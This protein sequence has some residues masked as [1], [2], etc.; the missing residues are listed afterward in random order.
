MQ[1]ER[2]IRMVAIVAICVAVI[3]LSIGYAAI[4]QTMNVKG[5]TNLKGNSWN[6]QFTN[7]IKP[8]L[9][10]GGLVGS[11][12]EVSSTLTGTNL[13]FSANIVLPGDTIVYRWSVTNAGTIDAKLSATPVL[14]GLDAAK[15]K[16][17]LYTMTYED[18][19][20]IQENDV[21]NA[22]ETKNI[23]LTVAF[24]QAATTI[25]STDTELALSTTLNYVQK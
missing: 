22:G 3:A 17:V 9:Q 18:G 2:G 4:N 1:K 7:L 13:S 24:A 8:T 5:T 11:A 20:A 14:A 12:S 25:P 19:S 23:V 6:V 16:D 21:L 15:E 10:N